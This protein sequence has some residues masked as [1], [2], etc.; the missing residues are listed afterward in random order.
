MSDTL[1]PALAAWLEQI[2]P[3]LEKQRAEGV[4]FTPIAAREALANVTAGLVTQRPELPWVGDAI[5]KTIDYPVPIRIYDPNPEEVKPICVYLHGGGHA[6]GSVSVYDGICRKLARASG[7][8]I[9]SVEYR[10]APECPYPHA[11]EDTEGVLEHLWPVLKAKERRF[12]KI[13]SVAGDS[14]GAALA[15]TVSSRAQYNPNISLKRQILVYPSVDYTGSFP[16]LQENGRGYFLEKDR[17]QWYFDNYFREGGDAYI[18][19]PLFMRMTGRMPETLVITAGFCPLRDE[20]LAY[21][22]RLKEQGIAHRHEHFPSMIHAFLNM[23]DLVPE[24]CARAYRVMGEF[25][26]AS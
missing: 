14:A 25:L 10:L 23:E 17:I 8:L 1:H 22:E 9:V 4:T 3:L 21:V 13:L 18:A 16:S 20:G 6:A 11:I 19:S 26:Q 7:N 15:A 24:E 12:Q 5:V 2:N